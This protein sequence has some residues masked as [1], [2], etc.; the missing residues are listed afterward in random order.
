MARLRRRSQ[1]AVP[2]SGSSPLA[3][4]D[5]APRLDVDEG[6]GELLER[7]WRRVGAVDGDGEHQVGVADGLLRPRRQLGIGEEDQIVVRALE[8][9][10]RGRRLGAVEL[11]A[12]GQQLGDAGTVQHQR[13]GVGGEHAGELVEKFFGDRRATSANDGD[14]ARARIVRRRLMR[15]SGCQP[16]RKSGRQ[17]A[18]DAGALRRYALELVAAEAQHETVAHGRYRGSARAAGEEGDLADRLFWP[19]LGE[20]LAAAFQ[21]DGKAAGYDDERA[22]R[23]YRPGGRAR[24]PASRRA[25]PGRPSWRC[26]RRRSARRI[27]PRWA[28]RPWREANASVAGSETAIDPA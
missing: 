19:D 16:L 25:S 22:H 4:D 13:I 15:G 8:L 1:R 26:A 3:H 23:L 12:L 18:P 2:D 21:G 9:I 14:G 17:R 27:F 5:E 7:I 11:D 24:R 28:G 6:G 20:R 10:E